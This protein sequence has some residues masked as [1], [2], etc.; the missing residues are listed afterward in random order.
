MRVIQV[1]MLFGLIVLSGISHAQSKNYAQEKVLTEY[2]FDSEQVEKMILLAY[3]NKRSRYTEFAQ[4]FNFCQQKPSHQ[5]C[6]ERYEKVTASYEMVKA[7]YNV[8]NMVNSKE[9][10]YLMMPEINY[11]EL[12]TALQD[13]GYLKDGMTSDVNYSDTL[14]ALNQWLVMHDMETTEHVYLLHSLMIRTEELAQVIL[15]EKES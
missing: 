9:L 7:N 12:V 13:L 10:Q 15:D 11:P 1:A 5:D 2:V 3:E 4:L 8:L 6:N 14:T